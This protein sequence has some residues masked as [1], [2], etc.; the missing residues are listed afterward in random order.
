[1]LDLIWDSLVPEFGQAYAEATGNWLYM[2]PELTH[3]GSAHNLASYVQS[4][5]ATSDKAISKFLTLV[6]KM[7][8]RH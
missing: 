6:K 2:L 3:S 7:N 5:K 1:M 4:K 8:E